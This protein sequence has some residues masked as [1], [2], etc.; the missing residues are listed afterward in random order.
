MAELN[1][2]TGTVLVM[3]IT[4]IPAARLAWIP[5]GASST[6]RQR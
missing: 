2:S 6:T 1:S 3:S 5:A 4:R